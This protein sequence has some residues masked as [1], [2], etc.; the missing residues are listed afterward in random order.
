MHI[1][2]GWDTTLSWD[3]LDLSQL[4]IL[5]VQPSLPNYC[6]DEDSQQMGKLMQKDI[7]VLFNRSS[8]TLETFNCHRVSG[9]LWEGT[10]ASLPKLHHLELELCVMSSKFFCAWLDVLPRLE[11]LVIAYEIR[12]EFE[13][14]HREEP[15]N[16]WKKVFD[17]IG[18]HPT[19][20]EANVK[21]STGIDGY[22][23]EF[24]YHK[25][26]H[27]PLYEGV[28]ESM[29]KVIMEE[30]LEQYHSGDANKWIPYYIR[31]DI[32]WCGALEEGFGDTT[33]AAESSDEWTSDSGNEVTS[34]DDDTGEDDHGSEHDSD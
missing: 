18:V 25:D 12:L 4:K 9:L 5:S 23:Y 29:L 21:F 15:S 3:R 10:P 34:E 17:A 33:G 16:N 8:A 24:Y 7:H 19:L 31:K 11:T 13:N 20:I 26:A 27:P 32:E 6:S 14:L 22:D 2:Y 1:D 30:W 28:T